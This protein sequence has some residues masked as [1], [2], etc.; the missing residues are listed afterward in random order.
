MVSTISISHGIGVLVLVVSPIP[1]SLFIC[2][3][4]CFPHSFLEWWHKPSSIAQMIEFIK[5]VK[6]EQSQ[7]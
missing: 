2:S 5:L 1:I 6:L 3:S 4:L 7:H